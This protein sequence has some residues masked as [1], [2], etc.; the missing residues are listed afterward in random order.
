MKNKWMCGCAGM[1]LM[2]GFCVAG[3]QATIIV[4]QSMETATNGYVLNTNSLGQSFT[5]TLRYLDAVEYKP[6]SGDTI[7]LSLKIYGYNTSG[8]QVLLYA[9]DFTAIAAINDWMKLELSTPV[10]LGSYA[11]AAFCLVP[12]SGSQMVFINA[13]NVYTGGDLLDCGIYPWT[14]AYDMVFRT[15][16]STVPE[17]AVCILLGIGGLLGIRR[18]S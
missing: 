8:S 4:D 3:A 10:D 12:D 2:V 17:P 9:Q 13:H 11:L 6:Y 5:P 1:V 18:K 14:N 16:G 7:D 15:W